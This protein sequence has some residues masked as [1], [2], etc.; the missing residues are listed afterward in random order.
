MIHVTRLDGS[1]LV[2]NSDH[3]LTIEQTPDTVLALTTG[4]RVMVKQ[5]AAE[6]VDQVVA[7]RKRIQ[8]EPPLVV[9]T[10]KEEP[11][12]ARD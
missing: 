10:T 4:L 9:D 5:T 2:V 12:Q 1:D 8:V 6:L 3:I 11:A 7:Y